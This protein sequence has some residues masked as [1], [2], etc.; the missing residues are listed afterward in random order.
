[1][2]ARPVR[3][4]ARHRVGRPKGLSHLVLKGHMSQ[5][6]RCTILPLIH[7]EISG[8]VVVQREARL[9]EEKYSEKPF[10]PIRSVTPMQAHPQSSPAARYSFLSP[11]RSLIS[12]RLS[13]S[14]SD[15]CTH[16]F[17]GMESAC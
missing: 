16:W 14:L 13:F 3:K 1:M 15:C 17:K 6:L 5:P 11:F 4:E 12:S 10:H 2:S 7:S 8:Y 9:L